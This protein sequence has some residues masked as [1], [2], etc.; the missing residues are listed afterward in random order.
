MQVVG[1]T[2]GYHA[3]A[4]MASGA[5]LSRGRRLAQVSGVRLALHSPAAQPDGGRARLFMQLDGEP[6]EQQVPA[7]STQERVVVSAWLGGSSRGSK[8]RIDEPA[9]LVLSSAAD[10]VV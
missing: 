5:K 3:M 9:L 4:V 1:F 2:H 8:W 6:W 10:A 7:G